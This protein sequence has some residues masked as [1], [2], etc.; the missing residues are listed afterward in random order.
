MDADVKASFAALEKQAKSHGESLKNISKCTAAIQESIHGQAMAIRDV[1]SQR[2]VC[3][4]EMDGRVKEAGKDAGKAAKIAETAH[5]R[6]DGL[7]KAAWGLVAAV[8]LEFLAVVIWLIKIA[9]T[10]GKAVP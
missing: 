8:L 2:L 4:A 9:V 3:R 10:T 6:I 7:A 5:R 1:A